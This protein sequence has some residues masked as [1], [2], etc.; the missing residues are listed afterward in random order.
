MP[1]TPFRTSELLADLAG[2]GDERVLFGE[3]VSAM[4]NRV[5]GIL[6]LLFGLPN[7][8]PM[9]PPIPLLCGIMLMWVAAQMVIGRDELWLPKRL[10][11]REFARKDLQRLVS[12]ARPWLEKLERFSKPRYLLL[13][14]TFARQIIGL[15]GLV[16]GAAL[17]LP[18]PF[19]GNIPPGIA[20][21]ILGLG[22]VER[23]GLMIL[24]GYVAAA[25]GLSLIGGLG[26]LLWQGAI[27]IF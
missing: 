18:I 3:L 23:D 14:D 4:R 19:I 20:V 27:S 8:L 16:L 21:C 5:F 12:R 22:L 6:F 24:A 2:T 15:V 1:P 11:A 25:M 7:C 17:M 10:A 13:T 9:P 26:W